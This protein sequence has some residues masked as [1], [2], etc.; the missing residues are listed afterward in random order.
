M[1]EPSAKRV[2][3]S[4]DMWRGLLAM[5]VVIFHVLLDPAIHRNSIVPGSLI[6]EFISWGPVR[7]PMFFVISG[8]CMAAAAAN[9]MDRNHS[10]WQFVVARVRRIYPPHLTV[11]LI[12]IFTAGLAWLAQDMGF[13]NGSNLARHFEGLTTGVIIANAVLLHGPLDQPSLNAVTWTLCY[14]VAFYAVM[15]IAIL[16]L[17]SKGWQL[18]LKVLHAVTVLTFGLSLLFP[19]WLV[20]PFSI[21]AH[22]TVGEPYVMV[23][24]WTS[25]G[26]GLL[27]FDLLCG[28]PWKE[29]T[30]NDK[31]F[32]IG[33]IFSLFILIV[34]QITYS[35]L[36]NSTHVVVTSLFAILLY[37]LH[38][39]DKRICGTK[40]LKGIFF[41]G[42][43][44]YSLYLTHSMVLPNWEKLLSALKIPM[45]LLEVYVLFALAACIAFAYVFYSLVEVPLIPS[46]S[47]KASPRV[48]N[49]E[50]VIGY[51]GGQIADG[52]HN[53]ADAKTD[54]SVSEREQDPSVSK[55]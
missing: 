55:R 5:W 18:M 45:P 43:I 30:T 33:V 51:S 27:L 3:G 46:K 42:S 39:F 15:A 19:T 28:K 41:V 8:Y 53:V 20:F 35:K 6:A 44:S 16:M 11:L 48:A 34:A 49:N 13:V 40:W 2:Y 32:Y 26:E 37:L 47:K 7:V 54:H 31:Y 4:L 38:P 36:P 10:S 24:A 21:P 22:V 52:L 1:K 25:F 9:T 12:A 23:N 17:R 50:G 14:E 29:R